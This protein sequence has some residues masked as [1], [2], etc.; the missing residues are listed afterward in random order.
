MMH[1]FL[2]Y[3]S[4]KNQIKSYEI[5]E[6]SQLKLKLTETGKLLMK[7]WMRV[8]LQLPGMLP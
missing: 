5:E 4:C 2:T 1:M 7:G 3:F 8:G 6:F